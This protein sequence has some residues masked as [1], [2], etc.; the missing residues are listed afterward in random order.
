[1]RRRGAGKTGCSGTGVLERDLRVRVV[2][3]GGGA[4]VLDRERARARGIGGFLGGEAGCE[5][6]LLG[7]LSGDGGCSATDGIVVVRGSGRVLCG[8]VGA[9]SGEADP[10]E[11]CVSCSSTAWAE[12]DEAVLRL[13]LSSSECAGR[14]L[15]NQG[16]IPDRGKGRLSVEDFP[17]GFFCSGSEGVG[18]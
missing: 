18:L 14:D 15:S 9:R 10:L 3:G 16:A 4:G 6:R 7:G 17:R 1:M 13:P 12:N 2:G 5:G 8:D 11:S